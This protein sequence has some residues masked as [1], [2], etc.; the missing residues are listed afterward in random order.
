MSPES[1]A[2]ARLEAAGPAPR[3]VVVTATP[4]RAN[5][6]ADV[7]DRGGCPELRRPPPA[8]RRTEAPRRAVRP[9]DARAD[10]PL[11][12]DD[13]ISRALPTGKASRSATRKP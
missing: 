13:A 10:Q 4:R 12:E 6:L 11:L 8:A 3:H 2:R 1:S 5:G 7:F 9:D